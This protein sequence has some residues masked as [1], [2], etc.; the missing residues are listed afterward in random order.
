MSDG[1]ENGAEQQMLFLLSFRQRD[2]LSA[3]AVR[4]GWQVVGARRSEGAA[5]RFRASGAVI[6]VID[7]RGACDDGLAVARELGPIAASDG[8]ALIVL[9]SRTDAGR[10]GAFFDAGA[11]QFLTSPM[12]ELEFAQALRFALRHVERVRGGVTPPSGGAGAVLGW[13]YDPQRRMLQ[14]TP[15]LADLA[16][17]AEAI[18]PSVAL[19][20]LGEQDRR[21]ARGALRRLSDTGSTAFAHDLPG[22]V[23]VVEHLHRDPETGR[24]HALVEPL[25]AGPD[26]AAMLRDAIPPVRDVAAARRWLADNAETGGAI[27]AAIIAFARFERVNESLG[28]RAGDALLRAAMR[29]IE[30][31]A[32]AGTIVARLAGPEFVALSANDNEGIA[33]LADR[34]AEAM[35]QPLVCEGRALT[36]DCRIATTLRA[37]NEGL[38]DVLRRLGALLAEVPAAG[39][40]VHDAAQP[41]LDR[42]ASELPDAIARGEITILF[43]PQVAMATGEIV[44]VEALAR[45][46]HPELGELGAETLFAAA[47]RADHEQVLSQHV[48]RRALEAAAGWPHPLSEL[49]LS[50]NVT[51]GDVASPDFA[52]RLI[53]RIDASG[54]PRRRVTVEITESG[55]IEELG[56]AARLLGELRAAGCRTAIDDF[57][58][59]Y[60]SLAYLKALPLDYLKIDKRLSQDIAGAARDR[61]VVR[62]VIEM[63]RSLGLTVIAEGVETDAQLELL[64]KEGCQIYQGFLCAPPVDLE[65]LIALVSARR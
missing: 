34:I 14:L 3:T 33:V 35:R 21:L 25:S 60:S 57:G 48:Q 28:R 44:G 40:V 41:G 8:S 16:D 62:G 23:R 38:S 46:L 29:R 4:A 51:A 26:A 58:T 12:R 10:I 65:A 61:V 32:G 52:D 64:A 50:I 54:F 24:L 43:Q 39:G 22:G 2:E 7:A 27:A 47:S 31:V 56:D 17:L 11:T 6:A 42:L 55:L 30:S 53:D 15:A 36:L 63:A 19:N 9:L 5:R 1:G 20:L 37:D 59:G 18:A 13:R 45:W 49:R